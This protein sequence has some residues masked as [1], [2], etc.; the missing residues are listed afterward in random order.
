MNYDAEI[1]RYIKFMNKLDKRGL[2]TTKMK[3]QK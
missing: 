2:E 1:E 3:E